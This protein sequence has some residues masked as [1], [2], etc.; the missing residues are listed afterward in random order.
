MKQIENTRKI[1]ITAV[2]LALCVVLPLAFHLIPG[3]GQTFSPMHIPVFLCGLACGPLY[4]LICGLGG[5]LLSHLF[6]SMPPVAFL[7]GMLIE[8]AVYG[9]V[10]G[11]CMQLIHSKKPALDVYLSLLI[12]MLAGR[13]VAGLANAWIFQVGTYNLQL[14][15]TAYF[16]KAWPGLVLHLIAV[17]AIYFA[18]LKAN[19]LPERYA[20][21]RH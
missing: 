1:A 7:P 9:L 6:T 8:L 13:L 20:G 19:L 10:A 16:V 3:E 17:P 15:L 12:A 4:G 14:W 5:P 2:C 21:T 18:L 11:L